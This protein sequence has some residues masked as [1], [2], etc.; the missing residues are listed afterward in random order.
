VGKLISS[1]LWYPG[2]KK[3]SLKQILTLIPSDFDEFREPFVG[4]GTT[5]KMAM[6]NNRNYI[7]IDISQ[8]Y[9]DLAQERI[10]SLIKD[11]LEP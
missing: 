9:C 1:P 2:G 7:G 6:L 3:R 4:G 5:L 11:D 10:N 8:E